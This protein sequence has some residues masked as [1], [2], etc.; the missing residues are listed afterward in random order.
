MATPSQIAS[1][2]RSFVGRRV[3]LS[4]AAP[5]Q[6]V[7][8]RL[9]AAFPPIEP[10]EIDALV[11]RGD[12]GALRSFL[13]ASAPDMRFNTFQILDQGGAMSLLGTPIASRAYLVG[14]ALIAQRMFE[15]EPAAGLGAPVRVVV[16]EGPEGRTHIDYD[17]PS[18]TFS[19]FPTLARSPVPPM[20]DAKLRQA[21]LAAL[22]EEA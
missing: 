1:T 2:E 12:P 21:F 6:T 17:E 13:E 4:S 10:R 11:A 14:N 19:Q 9:E 20:L 16:T 3:T 18:S 22:S 8:Q 5:F 7:V 15:L